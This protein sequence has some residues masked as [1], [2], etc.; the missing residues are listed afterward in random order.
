VPDI[1]IYTPYP[2]IKVGNIIGE[3]TTSVWEKNSDSNQADFG[4]IDISSEL[5]QKTLRFS[6]F[7]CA[8][9]FLRCFLYDNGDWLLPVLENDTQ[10]SR[11]LI[12]E[13]AALSTLPEI[14][15]IT[16]ENKNTFTSMSS[17]LTH[18]PELL[19]IPN[20]TLAEK[21]TNKG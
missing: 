19:Q 17:G 15:M 13:Y 10:I 5:R 6:L 18:T 20:Y 9:A 12:N 21:I 4:I 7:K 14:T 8:P 11:T 1:S 3:R 2:N 16:K